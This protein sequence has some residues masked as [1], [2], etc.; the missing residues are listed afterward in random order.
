MPQSIHRSATR[1]AAALVVGLGTVA[2]AATFTEI[3]DASNLFDDGLG[4]QDTGPGIDTIVAAITVGDAGD[5]FKL[6]LAAGVV[7]ITA[8]TAGGVLDPQIYLFDAS[9]HGIASNDNANAGTTDAVL[10]L[11][12]LAG[13]YYLGIG[14]ALTVAIDR[15]PGTPRTWSGTPLPPIDFGTL[16]SIESGIPQEQLSLNFAKIDLRY[17]PEPGTLALLLAALAGALGVRRAVR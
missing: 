17:V 7:A 13:T 6:S 11:P 12:I 2:S 4:P 15:S 9:G 10:V 5:L 8:T 16:G 14:H 3:G 1:L